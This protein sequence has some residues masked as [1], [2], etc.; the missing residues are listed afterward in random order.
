VSAGPNPAQGLDASE[1][2]AAVRRALPEEQAWI[3]GGAVRDAALGKAVV[4]LDLAVPEGRERDVARAIADEAGGFAFPLSERHKTWRAVAP[5]EAWHADVT[6]L[7][8][9]TIADDLGARDFAINAVAVPLA[10]G[11]PI[12]PAGGLR[13]AEERV[14]RAVSERSFTEDP[15]RLLRAARIAAAHGLEIDPETLALAR[16]SARLASEPAGERQFAELRGILCGPDPIRGLALMDELGITGVVLP[17]LEELRGVAQTANHHLDVHDHTLA[18]LEHLLEI[19]ADLPLYAGD[20][21]PDVAALMDEPVSDEVTHGCALRFGAL[22][23]DIGKPVTRAMHEGRVT[24]IGHDSAGADVI[25]AI[26]GRLKTSTRLSEHLQGLARHHLRLGFMVHERPLSR[27]AVYSY[28]RAT[29]PVAADVTLLTAADRM[30]AR[31]EGPIASDEMIA[32]HLELVREMLPE[33]IAW[34][35]DPPGPPLDGN[36]LAVE[37]GLTPGPRMGEILEELRVAEFAGELAD[38]EAAVELAREL[39]G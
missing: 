19:E 29:E 21:A 12:D 6:A 8:G 22:L 25:A 24:F 37:I 14:L 13:D 27:R 20:A 39:K 35:R 7:R 5:G 23:H 34:R 36:E 32:A 15:L 11:G 17:E 16:A 26:C 2:V 10:D 9:E 4:D 38:R 31:G 33:A 1:S 28:L 3:V 30:A 18:V